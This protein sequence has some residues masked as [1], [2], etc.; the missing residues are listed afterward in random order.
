MLHLRQTKYALEA[1]AS[2]AGAVAEIS[3]QKWFV[4]SRNYFFKVEVS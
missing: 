4:P 3:V 1:T 2:G